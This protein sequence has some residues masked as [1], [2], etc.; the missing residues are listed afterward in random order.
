MKA[1]YWFIR[2]RPD[3]LVETEPSAS[4]AARVRR[5]KREAANREL[6]L[7]KIQLG[8]GGGGTAAL[9]AKGQKRKPAKGPG[10]VPRELDW[11]VAN[12]DK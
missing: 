5:D 10:R 4:E 7:R 2:R 9:N 12:N 6:Q 3:E 11:H 8:T 1:K